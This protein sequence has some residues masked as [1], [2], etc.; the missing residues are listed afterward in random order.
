MFTAPRRDES[1]KVR[2]ESNE[3]P[4]GAYAPKSIS[5]MFPDFL[6]WVAEYAGGDYAA[7]NASY[8]R[9]DMRHAFQAGYEHAH[10]LVSR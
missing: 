3:P 9:E 6:R 7:A 8:S 4:T 2:K 1:M 5:E 10:K